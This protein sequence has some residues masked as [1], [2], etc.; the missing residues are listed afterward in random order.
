MLNSLHFVRPSKMAIA[1]VV[2]MITLCG[3][4]IG[5]G[6]SNWKQCYDNPRVEVPITYCQP[7]FCAASRCIGE[8]WSGG[9]S[10][11]FDINP[12]QGCAELPPY[13]TQVYEYDGACSLVV[14][15]FAIGICACTSRLNYPIPF[16]YNLVPLCISYYSSGSGS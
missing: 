5:T 9:S 2:G 13:W 8:W 11:G 16:T 14:G 10:C 12:F 3:S 7:T 4:A 6:G 1:A 15:S